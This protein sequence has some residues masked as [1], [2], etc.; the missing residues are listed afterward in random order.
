MLEERRCVVKMTT[1]AQRHGARL[2]QIW[3]QVVSP[4]TGPGKSSRRTEFGEQR[5]KVDSGVDG[6]FCYQ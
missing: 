5:I 4:C 2:I 3:I 6:C 1:E